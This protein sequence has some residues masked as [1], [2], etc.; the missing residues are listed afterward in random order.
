MSI[1][2]NSGKLTVLYCGI[3]CKR[4]GFAFD[5]YQNR[6]SLW[7]VTPFS[8]LDV[9]IDMTHTVSCLSKLHGPHSSQHDKDVGMGKGE[10]EKRQ[11]RS[12][13]LGRN[14]VC[15]C[16]ALCVTAV[17]KCCQLQNNAEHKQL[18]CMDFLAR[19]VQF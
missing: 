11:K 9:G 18:F 5:V 17:R 13:H 2:S 10:Y 16:F 8:F 3:Y 7:Q 15:G 1:W 14:Y 12:Y 4:C 19:S 6:I